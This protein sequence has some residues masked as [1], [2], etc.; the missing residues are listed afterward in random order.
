VPTWLG[1]LIVL[2]ADSIAVAVMLV[3]RRRAP[4]GGYYNDTQQAGWV[5][6]VAG[7]AF[8]V[9][10]AFVFLLTFQSF[11]RARTSASTEAEA[12][13][14]M[15]HTA[16]LFPRRARDALQGELICYAR[17]VISLEWPAMAADRDSPQ[18]ERRLREIE[19][20]FDRAPA[21]RDSAK[22]AGAYDA[23]FSYMQERQ[24]GRQGRLD[25]RGAFVPTLV[26][27]FLFA[28]GALVVCF[29]WL[30][31]DRSE[32]AFAQAALPVGVT[33]IVTAGLVM[34]AFFDAPY[35]PVAGAVR[36]EAMQRQLAVMQAERASD[37]GRGALPCDARGRIRVA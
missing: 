23:W 11:D 3:V 2:A 31:A 28:G 8:A 32:A 5:Y 26:W 4:E 14:A 17:G 9:V 18:V 12:T 6:S 24:D 36:P 10:L 19:H 21:A 13:G 34:V 22:T 25:E 1:I 20:T 33:T 30:F 35:Q 37:H 27:I 16:Q 7:T 15:F 29:V